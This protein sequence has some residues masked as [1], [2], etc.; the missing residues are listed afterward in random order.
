[1]P[2]RHE[3]GPPQIRGETA[4]S[5][6]ARLGRSARFV[7]AALCD[8]AVA[9]GCTSP[10]TASEALFSLYLDRRL[11]VLTD[12]PLGHRPEPSRT[13]GYIGKRVESSGTPIAVDRG[14]AAAYL[15]GVTTKADVKTRPLPTDGTT[16]A[17]LV[18][19]S[20][21]PD[22]KHAPRADVD[23][24]VDDTSWDRYLDEALRATGRST[25]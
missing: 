10:G 7:E 6:D 22:P 23:N 24:L 25:G 5:G 9:I 15:W 13:E 14:I 2:T 17:R 21:K 1:L 11:I 18:A 20:L 16:A 19:E 12:A 8:A 4:R 3:S